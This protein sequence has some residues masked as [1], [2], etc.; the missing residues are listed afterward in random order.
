MSFKKVFRIGVII[1]FLYILTSFVQQVI[2][3]A[4]SFSCAPIDC[5]EPLT[6]GHVVRSICELYLSATDTCMKYQRCASEGLFSC[7]TINEPEYYTCLSSAR[8]SP[9]PWGD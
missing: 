2:G 8:N 7:Q 9:F 1:I 4:I 3:K 6:C 5:H